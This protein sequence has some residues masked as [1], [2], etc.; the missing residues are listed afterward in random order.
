MVEG[1]T[2]TNLLCQPSQLEDL[3]PR[4]VEDDVRF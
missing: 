1:G 2:L 3:F 4:I